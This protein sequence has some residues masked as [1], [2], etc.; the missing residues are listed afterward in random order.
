MLPANAIIHLLKRYLSAPGGAEDGADQPTASEAALPSS[1]SA[2]GSRSAVGEEVPSRAA[3]SLRRCPA[4]SRAESGAHSAK[5]RKAAV[6][7]RTRA[8]T[9]GRRPCARTAAPRRPCNNVPC[10][11]RVLM[12]I[13]SFRVHSMHGP[14]AKR[15]KRGRR[16][17]PEGPRRPAPPTLRSSAP[18]AALCSACG[19]P[20]TTASLVLRVGSLLL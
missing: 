4:P 14:E 10:R 17:P 2:G 20:A 13:R 7:P 1:A 5:E 3:W 9:T 6:S 12:P 18:R 8:Q 15:S 19:A 11:G 16:Q